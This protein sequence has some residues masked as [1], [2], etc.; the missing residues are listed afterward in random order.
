MLLMIPGPVEV[1]PTVVDAFGGPPPGHLA[2]HVVEA[3][4]RALENMRRVWCA[5]P[6]SQPFIVPGSGTLAMEIAVDNLVGASTQVVVINTGYFSDR[7]AEMARR[8]GATVR[9]VAARPGTVPDLDDVRRALEDTRPQVLFATH[10]DTS[11]GVRVDPVPVCELAIE[12]GAL[13]VFDGVCATAAERF[14]MQE[15]GADVYLTASQKAIGLPPGLALMVVSARAMEHRRHLLDDVP[16]ALDWEQ[17]LPVMQAY[18]DRRAAYFSTPATNHIMALDVSL[19]E[20]VAEG[21]DD[22]FERHARVASQM[23]ASW[24]RMGIDL[25]C[26]PPVAANTL[27][28]LRY[29]E[30]HG[31]ELVARI[32][33][34]GVVVAGGLYPGLKNQ[35]FRVGHMGYSTTRPDHIDRTVAAIRAA[36]AAT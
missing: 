31:P 15:W 13:S 17:W 6:D 28:A 20:L 11:T 36:L 22:V 18:E 23:R 35:Y 25:L 8:R 24:T 2:P 1:S 21:M 26:D 4:G 34:E 32:A 29:P 14:E 3:H 9:E 12:F 16:M 33:Q 27:S 10:V 30:G 7:I 5:S 19:A